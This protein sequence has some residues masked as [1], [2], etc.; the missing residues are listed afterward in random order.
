MSKSKLLVLNILKLLQKKEDELIKSPY[1]YYTNTECDS[2][3]SDFEALSNANRLVLYSN[4]E[5]IDIQ[6]LMSIF[7]TIWDDNYRRFSETDNMLI[8]DV[9]KNTAKKNKEQQI[10]EPI[11]ANKFIEA[12]SIYNKK[13]KLTKGIDKYNEDGR[14][15]DI[16]V[17]NNLPNVNHAFDRKKGNLRQKIYDINDLIKLFNKKNKKD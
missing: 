11:N 2:N 15:G 5:C 6:L 10:F 17:Y 1:K 16:V 8:N 7:R 14:I 9:S 12:Y 13:L 3:V 4:L